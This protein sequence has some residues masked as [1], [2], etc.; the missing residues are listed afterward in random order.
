MIILPSCGSDTEPVSQSECTYTGT[1][2][3]DKHSEAESTENVHLCGKAGSDELTGGSGNDVLDGGSGSDRLFGQTG[4]D[5]FLGGTGNDQMTGGAGRDF[6]DGGEGKDDGDT[7]S[8]IDSPEGVVVDLSDDMPEKGGH[9]E[10]DVIKMVYKEENGQQYKVSTVEDVIGSNHPDHII[11]DAEDNYLAGLAGAD[12]L[13]GG[14]E[15]FEIDVADYRFS[16][17]PPPS[18]QAPPPSCKTCIETRDFRNPVQPTAAACVKVNLFDEKPEKCGHAEGDILINMEGAVGSPGRDI[19][20]GNDER[21][22]FGGWG[23]D[24][25]MYGGADNDTF[26]VISNMM[27]RLEETC[28]PAPA[29]CGFKDLKQGHDWIRDFDGGLEHVHFK[30]FDIE[31]EDDLSPTYHV[32]SC[33]SPREKCTVTSTGKGLPD[34]KCGMP[35]R[36]E[37][38]KECNYCPA[39][40]EGVGYEDADCSKD[41]IV[42]FPEDTPLLEGE[43][44]WMRFTPA[45][46]FA[47]MNNMSLKRRVEA[48]DNALVFTPKADSFNSCPLLQLLEGTRRFRGN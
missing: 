27:N 25:I 33:D 14:E 18:A 48:L 21:N 29:F 32:A 26:I 7:V 22:M 44:Q 10:G 4:D 3:P 45:R 38:E 17:H 42:I 9:A 28:P 24:D 1:D 20:V 47:E 30:C 37:E 11:G 15:D 39:H 41:L 8:Y 46:K 34:I 36:A 13:D 2:D 35:L 16:F 6:F 12:T 23:S 43:E 40:P 5:T 31:D 19:L